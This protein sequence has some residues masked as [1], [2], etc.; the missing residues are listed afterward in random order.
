M[1]ERRTQLELRRKRIER[2]KAILFNAV[3][4]HCENLAFVDKIAVKYM[5]C[6][7][8]VSGK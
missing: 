6:R 4:R 1:V 5:G 2:S 3:S 7:D 8:I